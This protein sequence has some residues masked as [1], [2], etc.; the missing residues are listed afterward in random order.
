[1]ETWPKDKTLKTKYLPLWATLAFQA[2][3][4]NSFGFLACGRFV[5]HVTGFGTQ[6]GLALGEGKWTFAL[7]MFGTPFFF[8]L[9]AFISGLY[10]SARQAKNLHPQYERVSATLPL[11][12]LALLIGGTQGWFGPFGEDLL[13]LH[14]FVLLF[15]LSFACGLQNACFTTLTGGFI[16]TTHLTGLSTDLGIDLSRG[17]YGDVSKAERSM[18]RR[19]NIA[20]IVT[21]LAFAAGSIVSIKLSEDYHYF[22]LGVPLATSLLVFGFTLLLGKQGLDG[23]SKRF[24]GLRLWIL[25]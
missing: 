21:F 3:F 25:G 9:G 19:S 5:S 12:L 13:Y 15:S 8:I 16:R 10:T 22:S 7:E 14:D 11:I 2:G 23:A 1:M 18:L 6:V 20:R 4:I 17:I 24:T